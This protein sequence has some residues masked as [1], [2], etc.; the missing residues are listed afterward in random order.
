MRLK[1]FCPLH[2]KFAWAQQRLNIDSIVGTIKQVSKNLYLEIPK[3]Y[4]KAT[5]HILKYVHESMN[6]MLIYP[7]L[8]LKEIFVRL[9]RDASF[10]GTVDL[11]ALVRLMVFLADRKRCHVLH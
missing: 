7:K 2:V 5:L 8:D 1:K 3:W 4:A 6:I 9:N 10:S 11:T